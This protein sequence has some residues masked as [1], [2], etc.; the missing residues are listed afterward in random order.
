[1]EDVQANTLQSYDVRR[2]LSTVKWKSYC[3]E[4]RKVEQKA[5]MFPTKSALRNQR[6]A[7]MENQTF[8]AGW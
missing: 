6:S 5:R 3:V 8:L 4:I 2:G 1:M 7:T